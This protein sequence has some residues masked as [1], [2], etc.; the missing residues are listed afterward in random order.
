MAYT[1][2]RVNARIE[3]KKRI[4]TT[5]IENPRVPVLFMPVVSN[6][7]PYTVTKVRSINE[8]EDIYGKLDSTKQGQDVLNLYQWIGQVAYNGYAWI[9][10]IDPSF[11]VTNETT[12]KKEY[13]E[14]ANTLAKAVGSVLGADN[15]VLFNFT[16]KE[17]GD[18]YAKYNIEVRQ[19][20]SSTGQL[21][22][23]LNITVSN[24]NNRVIDQIRG[25]DAG[26][27]GVL[28]DGLADFDISLGTSTSFEVT[29][30]KPEILK[31]SASYINV[32]LGMEEDKLS[33]GL[34]DS[35]TTTQ[36]FEAFSLYYRYNARLELEDMLTYP[37][38][39][40]LD[41]NYPMVLKYDIIDFIIEARDDLHF[42]L[43]R[44]KYKE[45]ETPEG[46][47]T[48]IDE[49]LV[50]DYMDDAEVT[51]LLSREQ[52]KFG[53]VAIFAPDISRI[54][55]SLDTGYI[56][57]SSIYDLASK[58]PY[59]DYNY[60]I[61][62]NFVGPRRGITYGELIHTNTPEDKKKYVKNYTNYIEKTNRDQCF[63]LQDTTASRD[64]AYAEL[65]ASRLTQ[66]IRREITWIGRKYLFEY[67]DIDS[68]TYNECKSEIRTFLNKFAGIAIDMTRPYEL[69]VFK[70][71]AESF[72][73]SL[74]NLKYKDVVKT[75]DLYIEL[76]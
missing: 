23:E 72:R 75:V 26:N 22:P 7:G 69:D 19:R 17:A 52:P 32:T 14:D 41:G 38:S 36:I 74:T 25:I 68:T 2:P 57:V 59:N 62:W 11:V 70:I 46:Q 3:A 28:L 45:K 67:N 58:I 1:F 64:T 33:S 18:S 20:K 40:I 39:I 65:H 66:Y 50:L 44:A 55:T 12:L 42:M 37:I 48:V 63:M 4:K 76:D 54:S 71:D 53:N 24:E 47:Y 8:F 61:W 43:S 29:L 34:N 16:A 56:D 6:K 27:V 15:K 5:I 10:R 51:D 60:G 13:V 73:I 49:P 31:D 35:L 9:K 30:A 21:L